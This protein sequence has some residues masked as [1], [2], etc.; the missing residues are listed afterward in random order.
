[1]RAS[2]FFSVIKRVKRLKMVS[3]VYIKYVGLDWTISVGSHPT[4]WCFHD[5]EDESE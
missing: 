2:S 4:Q 1:M 5:C 3:K